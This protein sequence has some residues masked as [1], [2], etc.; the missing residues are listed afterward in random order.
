M[1]IYLVPARTAF[2]DTLAGHFQAAAP[3]GEGR[4]FLAAG[5][6]TAPLP[7]WERR[8]LALNV[9]RTLLELATLSRSPD[10]LC[11]RLA[12]QIPETA[13]GPLAVALLAEDGSLDALSRG[14][15]AVL[16]GRVGKRLEAFPLRGERL[17]IPPGEVSDET[18]LIFVEGGETR[19]RE[20]ANLLAQTEETLG[21]GAARRLLMGASSSP[22]EAALLEMRSTLWRFA[23]SQ[24]NPK[25]SPLPDWLAAL[26][27]WL[28]WVV[29]AVS[30]LVT[31]LALLIALSGGG[32]EGVQS[33]PPA[34]PRSVPTALPLQEESPETPE[35]Q[36]EVEPEETPEEEPSSTPT[37]PP[38]PSSQKK[39]GSSK[40]ASAP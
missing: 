11:A 30:L 20:L 21:E 25:P 4:L 10:D 15:G 29:A 38:K 31:L 26:T 32:G 39:P 24:K 3:A 2:S 18:D 35:T 9:E 40:K 6:I 27:P 17:Q 1:E 19:A 12:K 23:A 22:V 7:P 33:P 13:Y 34:A 14:P 8:A 36:E 28:P 37:T 5:R 16:L